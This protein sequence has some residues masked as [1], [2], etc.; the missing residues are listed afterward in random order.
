MGLC[1]YLPE[2]RDEPTEETED[3]QWNYD[4]NM[5]RHQFICVTTAAQQTAQIYKE[6]SSHKLHV[7]TKTEE[8]PSSQQLPSMVE[9]ELATESAG[10]IK[11][12]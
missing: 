3:W 9:V 6:K 8:E 11:K 2:G 7:H 5:I 4:G 12:R 10:I 1:V